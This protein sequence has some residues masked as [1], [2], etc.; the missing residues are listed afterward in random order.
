MRSVAA[1]VTAMSLAAPV[2]MAQDTTRDMDLGGAVM[3]DE[4]ASDKP[5]APPRPEGVEDLPVEDQPL[6]AADS[7]KYVPFLWERA[8]AFHAKG[9]Y[10]KACADFDLLA[11]A[12]EDLSRKAA[13]V[14][15][16]YL[17]CARLKAEQVELEEARALLEK[18]RRFIGEVPEMNRVHGTIARHESKTA[19]SQGKLEDAIAAFDRASTAEPDAT[20][21]L[22]FSAD[23]T[24]YART[25]YQK[26]DLPTAHRA[27]AAALRFFPENREARQL[28]RE[29]W[30]R[31]HF[32]WMLAAAFAALGLAVLAWLVVRRLGR[33]RFARTEVDHLPGLD[34]AEEEEKSF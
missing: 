19:L 24:Y 33:D 31:E 5:V 16:S 12:N 15:R 4:S 7:P 8:A 27:L 22:R 23:M 11:A 10:L 2:A 28:E 21:P 6:P 32:T 9:M 26:E 29:L 34:E 17:A 25:A 20:D 3:L 1:L 18:T 13:V 30:V 14:G